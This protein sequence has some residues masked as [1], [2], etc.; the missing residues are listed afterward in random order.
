MSLERIQVHC[1]A[2]GYMY[3]SIIC[4]FRIVVGPDEKFG[5]DRVRI[6]ESLCLGQ[7]IKGRCGLTGFNYFGTLDL[8]LSV[9][10]QMIH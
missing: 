10:V 8:L 9:H 4:L 7:E 6:T 1:I 2:K 3:Y 5:L